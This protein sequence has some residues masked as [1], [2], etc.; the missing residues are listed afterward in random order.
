LAAGALLQSVL[1]MYYV[2]PPS[3]PIVIHFPVDFEYR[4]LLEEWLSQRRGRKVERRTPQRGAKREMLEL[5]NR[6]ARLS[7]LQRFR[8]VMPSPATISK[9]VEEVLDLEKPPRRIECFDISNL[10]GSDVVASMVVG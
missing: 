5:V 10:Q 7:Y 1:D 4:V 8:A 9:D 3:V 2:E 6:N